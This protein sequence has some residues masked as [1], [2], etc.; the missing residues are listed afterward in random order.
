[1]GVPSPRHA[2]L[3]DS[4]KLI[5]ICPDEAAYQFGPG[6]VSEAEKPDA[7]VGSAAFP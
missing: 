7:F 5:A 4:W 3:V 1:M 6:K 2:H